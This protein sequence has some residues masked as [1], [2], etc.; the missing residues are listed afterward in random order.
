MSSSPTPALP[1][2]GIIAD[3]WRALLTGPWA[4]DMPVS[5][6]RS[7]F[8]VALYGAAGLADDC[9]RVADPLDGEPLTVRLGRAC[10]ASPETVARYLA[11]ATAAGLLTERPDGWALST[12]AV[13]VWTAALAHLTPGESR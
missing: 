13:P 2:A 6:R 5:L 4:R 8:L 12:A 1:S 7:R 9:G 10:A 3:V 11:A